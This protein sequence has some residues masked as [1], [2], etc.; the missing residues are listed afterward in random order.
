[1]SAIGLPRSSR[2]SNSSRPP[3][4]D[5]VPELMLGSPSGGFLRNMPNIQ[6]SRPRNPSP[7]RKPIDMEYADD[8]VA[9]RAEKAHLFASASQPIKNKK[10]LV[11][12]AGAGH[13][14]HR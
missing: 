13:S 1:M 11:E 6:V 9:S 4:D 14:P 7:A 3:A 5:G 8:T 12:R 2:S 10:T